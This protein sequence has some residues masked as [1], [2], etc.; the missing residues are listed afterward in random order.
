MRAHNSTITRNQAYM[1]KKK[2][3]D[4]ITGTKEE[5]FDMLWDYCSKLGVIQGPHVS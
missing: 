4:V 2:A 3:L 5:Q 1:E